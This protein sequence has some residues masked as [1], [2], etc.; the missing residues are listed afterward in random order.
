MEWFMDKHMEWKTM[1]FL[2]Y[3]LDRKVLG[4]RANLV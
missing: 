2:V 4:Q 1:W 3:V